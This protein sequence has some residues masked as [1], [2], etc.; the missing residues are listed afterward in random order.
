MSTP[1]NHLSVREITKSDFESL[2]N[3]FLMV[4]PDFLLKMGV[5]AAALF[6]YY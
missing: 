5:D 6:K 4:E 3:Y 2:V 1:L